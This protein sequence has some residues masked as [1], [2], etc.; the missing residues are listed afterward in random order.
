MWWYIKIGTRAVRFTPS[1]VG[2]GVGVAVG[3]M[4]G[5]SVATMIRACTPSGTGVTEARATTVCTGVTVLVD[6]SVKVGRVVREGV[7]DGVDCRVAVD[8]VVADG[9]GLSIC[10]SSAAGALPQV[11][12]ITSAVMVPRP[13]RTNRAEPGIR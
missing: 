1:G 5:G 11:G 10:C 13:I 7:G 6:V 4:V 2:R 3:V 8:Q 12:A 9:T